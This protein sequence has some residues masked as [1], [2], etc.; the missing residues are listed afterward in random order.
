MIETLIDKNT[1]RGCRRWV[2]LGG[3]FPMVKC[4][5]FQ[6]YTMFKFNKSAS[7]KK[8]FVLVV[9]V[10]DIVNV[11]R[12]KQATTF[13]RLSGQLLQQCSRIR[14]A[15]GDEQQLKNLTLDRR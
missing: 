12:I 15:G 10:I 6:E 2:G 1:G 13:S 8:S 5:C 4:C 14:V 11:H 7:L 9:L 3:S